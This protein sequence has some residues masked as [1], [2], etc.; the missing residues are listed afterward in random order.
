MAAPFAFSEASNA[1]PAWMGASVLDESDPNLLS[2][3]MDGI[4][5]DEACEDR[6][7]LA[8]QP[9]T[10]RLFGVS[11][12]SL[13]SELRGRA[14]TVRARLTLA[15][16]S[17]DVFLETEVVFEDESDFF[18]VGGINICETPEGAY[19]SLVEINNAHQLTFNPEL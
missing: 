3:T 4:M 6:G 7:V 2:L 12:H 15:M 16:R 19:V 17:V 9:G 18:I 14:H 8:G 10:R 1:M 11:A 13:H 5:A